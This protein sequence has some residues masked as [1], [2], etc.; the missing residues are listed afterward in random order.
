MKKKIKKIVIVGATGGSAEVGCIIKD[1]NSVEY[2]YEIICYLDD[3]KTLWGQKIY[4]IE[5]MG[6]A[7]MINN[8]NDDTF[9]IS[10][11]GSQNSFIKK[12]KIINDWSIDKKKYATIIHPSAVVSPYASI[13]YGSILYPNVTIGPNVKLGN[14]VQVLPN[15][16]I[17]HHSE[18]S[19]FTI[20]NGSCLIAGGVKIN[21]NCYIGANTSIRQNVI[22]GS[23][24]L[25]GMSSLVLNDIPRGKIGWGSPFKIKKSLL[26]E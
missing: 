8:F 6:G 2:E 19:D 11:I 22:I 10:G 4:D 24:V 1:I 26:N 13:G 20:I 7:S 14:F 25:I 23:K 17:S 16:N 18:I 3:N 21:N 5:V 15:T 12:P 9:F